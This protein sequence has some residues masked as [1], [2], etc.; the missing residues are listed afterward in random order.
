[1]S[2]IVIYDMNFPVSQKCHI[3]KIEQYYF[4][5]HNFWIVRTNGIFCVF[6][7]I[8]FMY[9]KRK[10]IR[11]VRKVFSFVWAEFLILFTLFPKSLFRCLW[12]SVR[13][14]FNCTLYMN[15]IYNSL[16]STDINIISN[17]L[18]Y[19][20]STPYIIFLNGKYQHHL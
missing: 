17:I 18:E 10:C 13:K 3:R 14:Y 11:F 9:K 7:W 20:L 15:M 2:I 19:Q 16:L 12:R 4:S 5:M 6:K 8:H 1:M